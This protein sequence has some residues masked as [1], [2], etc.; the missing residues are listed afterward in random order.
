MNGVEFRLLGPVGVWRDGDQLG[1]LNAQQRTLLT[2]LLLEPGRMIGI[3]RLMTALWGESPPASARNAV[4]GHVSKLRRLLAGLPGVELATTGPGY[5]LVVDSRRVDLHQFREMVGRA[6]GREGAEAGELLRTAL[7][8]W[9]GPALMDVAGDWLPDTVGVSLEEERLR[10]VEERVAADLEVGRH[11]D[12]VAELST[13]VTAHPLRETSVCLLMAALERSGR[14][15]DALALFRRTRQRLIE[16]LGIEPGK[17]LR[18]LHRRVLEGEAAG[19]SQPDRPARG[20]T[21][22]RQLPADIAHFTG[23]TRD[24]AA[25]DAL[26]WPADRNPPPTPVIAAIGGAAGVGKTALAVHWARRVA[27]RFPDGQLFVDLRGFD[28]AGAEMASAE[29]LRR[30]LDALGVPAHQLPADVEARASLFRTVVAERQILIVLDNAR[31]VEQVRPLLPGA[32]GCLVLVNSRSQLCGLVA[33]N[34]ANPLTLDRPSMEE[35]REFLRH[36]VGEER[37]TAEHAAA[38]EIIVRC[39][40]LP[41]ALA[42]VAARAATNAGFSLTALAA[43]LRESRG[44]LDAFENGDAATDIRTVFSWSYGTLSDGAA[45]LFRLLGL[46]PGPDFAIPAAA[47]LASVGLRRVR[48]LLAELTRV[49][50][51]HEHAPGRY[52]FHDLLRAYATELTQLTDSDADGPNSVRSP[53]RPIA[54]ATGS[55]SHRPAGASDSGQSPQPAGESA[56]ERGQRQ[57]R[58][59][60]QDCQQGMTCVAGDDGIDHSGHHDK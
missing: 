38:E 53:W 36:R 12:L 21:R 24:L 57:D 8:L 19:A 40:R 49:H 13:L 54:T 45:R 10:A 22:P 23:R 39:A 60:A 32:P 55:P 16:E 1:P 48:S 3:D 30:F 33:A 29:A 18:R 51:L 44:R 31:D 15:S 41:L 42:I 50:L 9:Q 46:H 43:E 2:M 27:D 37:L 56:G 35:A 58:Q 20:G 47:S 14:R 26:I 7:S 59:R 52:T 6:R 34:G 25:L 17:D 11:H 4:Q 5:H 28:P